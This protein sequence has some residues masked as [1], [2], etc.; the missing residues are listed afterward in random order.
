[1]KHSYTS[2]NIAFLRGLNSQRFGSSNWK[3]F[4]LI[5]NSLFKRLKNRVFKNLNNPQNML[6]DTKLK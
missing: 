4:L 6:N 3:K 5:S 1:M 2:N